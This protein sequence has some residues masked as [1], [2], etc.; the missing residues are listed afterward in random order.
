[1]AKRWVPWAGACAV[2][3]AVAFLLL[4]PVFAALVVIVGLTLV[5][6]VALAGDWERH[7]TY[8]EREL[9]RAQRR[10]AR[11]ERT[12]AARGRDRTRWEAHQARKGRS[13][14]S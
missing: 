6:V 12:R 8:E 2:A 13:G 1:M 11:R 4:D 9:A 14:P 7:S 10:A 5:A 3:S